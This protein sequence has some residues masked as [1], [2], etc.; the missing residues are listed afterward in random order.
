MV[1]CRFTTDDDN[2]AHNSAWQTRTQPTMW[3]SDPKRRLVCLVLSRRMPR[4]N[5]D[6][7]FFIIISIKMF[8]DLDISEGMAAP[9]TWENWGPSNTR[10]FSYRHH[11]VVC[12]TG[13]RVL[14]HSAVHGVD[15]TPSS[16]ASRGFALHMMDFSA[17]AVEH[18]HCLGKVVVKEPST[19][20]II[21]SGENLDLTTSLPY[22]EVVSEKCTSMRTVY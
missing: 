7:S 19:I 4:S 2:I 22:V 15:T 17:L 9:I 20:Q 6:S 12:A 11:R 14:F 8:F 3:T 18:Q 13:N 5:L 21:A 16:P 10:I 1:D